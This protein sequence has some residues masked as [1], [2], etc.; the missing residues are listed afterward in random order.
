MKFSVLIFASAVLASPEFLFKRANTCDT[1][2]C[3]DASKIISDKCDNKGDQTLTCICNLNNDDYWNKVS[4]CAKDC[5][6]SQGGDYSPDALKQLYCQAAQYLSSYSLAFPTSA[7]SAQS[8]DASELAAFSIDSSNTK[9]ASSAIQ[10]ILNT[11]SALSASEATASSTSGGSSSSGSGSGSRG[12]VAAS[13]TSQSGSGSS[14]NTANAASS[15]NSRSSSGSS[16]GS[17]SAA[18]SSSPASSSS[19]TSNV[20]ATIGGGSLISLIILSLL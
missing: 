5:A 14:S 2:S 18:S 10:A 19:R 4:Q 16:S 3:I 17:S 9:D 11:L 13:T 12:G 8:F 20:A 1:Q 6:Q 7:P 15:S